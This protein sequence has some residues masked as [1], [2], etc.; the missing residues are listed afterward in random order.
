M[1][2]IKH[3]MLIFLSSIESHSLRI[4]ETLG[5]GPACGLN[6]ELSDHSIEWGYLVRDQDIEPVWDPDI[7]LVQHWETQP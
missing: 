6:L 1:I 5:P 2:H 7:E 4:M 3:I